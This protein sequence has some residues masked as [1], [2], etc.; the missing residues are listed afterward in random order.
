MRDDIHK[1]VPRPPQV[2]KWV[3]RSINDADRQN[4]RSLDALNDAIDD[5]RKREISS[6]FLRGM[7]REVSATPNLF[8]PLGHVE[9]ARD[10]GGRGG[11][12]ESEIFSETKRMIAGGQKPEAA[13]QTATADALRGR[14]LA[15]IRLTEPVLLG[16]RDAKAAV[17]IAHMKI[18][19]ERASYTAFA[20]RM[21]GEAAAEMPSRSSGTLTLDDDLLNGAGAGRAP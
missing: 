18:E 19:A 10:V 16:T 9:T 6:A 2:Q 7:I 15:D 20:K 17:V 13:F 1:K 14:V 12:L 3:K 21:C 8:G 5:M 4:G 11:H